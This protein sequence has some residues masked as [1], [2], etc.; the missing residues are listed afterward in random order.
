[1]YLTTATATQQT[2]AES[3]DRSDSILLATWILLGVTVSVF[4][5]RQVLKAVVL[6]KVT[7][8]DLLI[9]LATLSWQVFSIALSVTTSLLAY[10]GLSYPGLLA[11][12]RASVLMKGNY[13]SDF[14]YIA[15]L[16]FSKI[17]LLPFF[18]TV[19]PVQ[20]MHQ[21]AIAGFATFVSFWSIASIVAIAFQCQ[22]PTPWESIARRCFDTPHI[23][24]PPQFSTQQWIMDAGYP[25]TDP[26]CGMSAYHIGRRKSPLHH[27]LVLSHLRDLA[28]D[29]QQ[30]G[31][32]QRI[33]MA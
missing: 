12:E 20:R 28:Y 25:F 31:A 14:L 2:N 3:Q 19:L 4:F 24:W 15:S 6:Q 22:L 27:P 33:V 26:S 5:A 17:S 13:A 29:P 21:K 10:K 11:I 18:Y 9:F 16:Y 1:M 30:H 7:V 32:D 8:D 23:P